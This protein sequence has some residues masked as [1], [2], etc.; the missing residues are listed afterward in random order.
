MAH[1]NT[2]F[3][4]SVNAPPAE[5]RGKRKSVH[6][7]TKLL[8]TR[9]LLT[10][11]KYS[12]GDPVLSGLKKGAA[13]ATAAMAEAVHLQNT[14]GRI[15]RSHL[16]PKFEEV[17]EQDGIW[18]DETVPPETGWS[19]LNTV[20]PVHLVKCA[21]QLWE[22]GEG[23]HLVIVGRD[24]ES[25]GVYI[26]DCAT[27]K[28]S[29][30]EPLR[31]APSARY[32]HSVVLASGALIIF[33]GWTREETF[34][35]TY[36]VTLSSTSRKRKFTQ[37]NIAPAQ[38][39]PKRAFHSAVLVD[40][41]TMLIF[42][43]AS[44]SWDGEYTYL[45]D[46]WSLNIKDF[47]WKPIEAIGECPSARAQH[48]AVMLGDNM[49]V[50][51]GVN[52]HWALNDFFLLLT[53]QL[54]WR[55]LSTPHNSP[56]R[57]VPCQPRHHKPPI[58]YRP[59][60]VW[61]GVIYFYGG[62]PIE[63]EGRHELI[64]V[65]I[66]GLDVRCFVHP[67]RVH[68]QRWHHLLFARSDGSLFMCGGC[69]HTVTYNGDKAKRYYNSI[70]YLDLNI[71]NMLYDPWGF[72]AY[73]E[74]DGEV[75]QYNQIPNDHRGQK[76]KYSDAAT[77]PMHYE[78]GEMVQYGQVH[79]DPHGQ[80]YKYSEEDPKDLQGTG[81]TGLTT[82]SFKSD[83]GFTLTDPLGGEVKQDIAD[84]FKTDAAFTLSDPMGGFFDDVKPPTTKQGTQYG[85]KLTVP[86][87]F[88]YSDRGRRKNR[89]QRTFDDDIYRDH[90]P[91]FTSKLIGKGTFGKVYQ[92]LH[93]ETGEFV[94]V[95]QIKAQGVEAKEREKIK[96]EINLLSMLEH[97]YIV[98]YL[99]SYVKDGRVNIVMEY[100]SGGSLLG[101]IQNYQSQGGLP[102]IIVQRYVFQIVAGIDYLHTK[103][104]MH[105]D[106]KPANIL[107]AASGICKVADFG[108]SKHLSNRTMATFSHTNATKTE[109]AGTPLYMAPE[110]IL[111]KA[112][113]RS[114]VWSIG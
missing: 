94:A 63:D 55:Q 61:G 27:A 95:K 25:L 38:R 41:E 86:G 39:P 20:T 88:G 43:G 16:H 74:G 73:V 60:V 47:V 49:A 33:G 11:A 34:N 9:K 113:L 84:S 79:D 104:L 5:L 52:S 42:G 57:R 51:C 59:A 68:P 97:K 91:V 18:E 72:A 76:F 62:G 106:I 105:R 45:D 35:E 85:D 83:P 30:P 70:F 53:H 99:G 1:R 32:G 66:D 24:R 28:W 26:M 50:M 87:E 14:I 23:G 12:I 103:S 37:P 71:I 65:M 2:S 36:F 31:G 22:K 3:N 108:A 48:S 54:M 46:L 58:A 6:D 107:V 92:G 109:V 100:C 82:D 56:F 77:K 110:M 29:E 19:T 10:K 96:A 81:H 21:G 75:D 78:E 93:P 69:D 67:I 40:Y 7:F 8:S 89:K 98:K 111:G 13:T 90:V 4:N 102:E 15:T 17:V 112:D 101:L 44:C 114:D 64:G 80:K